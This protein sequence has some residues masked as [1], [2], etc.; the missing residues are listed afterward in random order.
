VGYREIKGKIKY[1]KG[2][3]ERYKRLDAY[4][5]LREGTLYDHIRTP[6][7]CEEEGGQYIRMRERRPSI[8]WQCPR[9][10][11]DQ[12]SGLLWGDEQMPI[13]RTY[14]GEEPTDEDKAAEDGIQHLVE[15]LNLDAV[16]DEITEKAS[17]GSAA[18]VLR[19]V[20]GIEG[21]G[22]DPYI[23][24]IP[25]KECKPTFD[26]KNPKKLV[27]IEQL[28]PT[29]GQALR[30]I[31]YDKDVIPD[32]ELDKDFWFRLEIDDKEEIRYFP[33]R[34]DR[35]ERLGQIEGGKKIEWEIDKENS[36]A[37]EW[38]AL[39]VIWVKGPKGN[40]IDGDCLYGSIIDILVEIDYSLSQ[41]GRGYRYTADPMLAY[42]RGELR[43]GVI[44]AAFDNVED[45]TQRDENGQVIKSPNNV[46]DIEP[47][48]DA[49]YLE[50]SGDGL[51]SS[52][53]F[54]KLLRE[55]GLE[56]CGGMKSDAETTS[57]V[58]SGR[59]LEILY[60][61]LILV[62][63]RWRVAVGNG[64]FLPLIRMLLTGM[65]DGVITVNGVDSLDP[66]TTMRLV[67]PQWMTPS[68]SDLLASA[69]AWQSLAGGSATAPVPILPRMTVTRIAGSNLGM[70]DVSTL[71]KTLEKQNN[72][73]DAD[74]LESEDRAHQRQVEIKK[75][76]TKPK[77]I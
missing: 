64:A 13:V 29:T 73:D 59:A 31:G 54:V 40:R 53:E 44:P 15:I 41:I 2:T 77:I 35:Y 7:D 32:E 70:P 18:V 36:I 20:E 28:Y 3:T 24:I 74:Q 51:K 76:S 75:V 21:D 23:E 8:I 19:A 12:L 57:G 17:S 39:P 62:I 52:G 50:I 6:F 47:G 56:I 26:P 37:H 16:M 1:P 66:K 9:L 69:Q 33:M 38:P 71:I 4:D 58:Q 63:K 30:D 61:A 11:V 34:S 65:E 22:N 5:R 55:W 14:Y 25:G 68:G 43:Q 67:W 48:G 60:Q 10:I 45:R 27:K 72:D 49:K 42:K 46:L